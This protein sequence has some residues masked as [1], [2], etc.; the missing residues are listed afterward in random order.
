MKH[1]IKF[2]IDVPNGKEIKFLSEYF[3][4]INLIRLPTPPPKKTKIIDLKS[5][6]MIIN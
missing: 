2:E 6:P 3:V 4:I 5:K 1:P